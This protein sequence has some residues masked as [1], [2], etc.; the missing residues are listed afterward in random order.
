MRATT[1]EVIGE[2]AG[3]IA[4]EIKVG[5]TANPAMVRLI[6]ERVAAG[7][8]RGSWPVFRP[9]SRPVTT[10]RPAP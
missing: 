7:R 9:E 8:H 4:D 1:H 3:E 5:G 10:R 2:L 6:R